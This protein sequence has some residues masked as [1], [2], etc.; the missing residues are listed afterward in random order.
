MTSIELLLDEELEHAVLGEWWRLEDAGIP[1]QSRHTGTSNR[2][3]LTLLWADAGVTPAKLEGV[4]LPVGLRLGA[5]ILF[6]AGRKGVILARL[7]IPSVELLELHRAVH[8]QHSEATGIAPKTLP[9]AWTPHVTLSRGIPMDQLVA[10]LETLDTRAV[11]TGE[12]IAARHWDA[13]TAA[14]TAVA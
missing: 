14:V 7:V 11:L 9:G 2:P 1:N 4:T 10:A 12:A 5:P 13:T 3:H 8:V 6:G